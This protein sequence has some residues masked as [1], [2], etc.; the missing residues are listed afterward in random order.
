MND[1]ATWWGEARVDINDRAVETTIRLQGGWR[2]QGR[3]TF[4]SA[5]PPPSASFEAM[6]VLTFRSDGS[7]VGG[8]AVAFQS[9]RVETDGRFRTVGLPA[10]RYLLSVLLGFPSAT[11]APTNLSVEAIRVGG[12][13]ATGSGIELNGGDVSDITVIFTDRG[14]AISGTVEGGDDL[15]NFGSRLYI[16]PTDEHHWADCGSGWPHLRSIPVGTDGRFQDS[17]L[18]PGDYFV[19]AA[20]GGEDNWARTEFLRSLVPFATRVTLAL[21]DKASVHVKARPRK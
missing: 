11:A 5:N 15:V 1:D 20:I 14:P 6:P 9:G 18:P 17:G 19:A 10:G 3:V 7:G 21:G 12:R 13:D 4:D 2:L 16:F 8:F